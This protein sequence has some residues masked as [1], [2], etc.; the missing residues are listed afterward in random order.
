MDRIILWSFFIIGIVLL[1]F[2]FRKPLIKE[3]KPI[4]KDTILVFLMKAYFSTF[5]GI[6]VAKEK[7]IE[8]PVRFL[9]KYFETSIIFESFLYPIMCVYLFQTTYH[10][11][12]LGIIVQCALYT[13]ALTIIEVFCEKYTDLIH[14]HTWTWMHSFITIFLLSLFVRILMQWINKMDQ[15]KV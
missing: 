8:Y 7:M 13:A 5:I 11:R 1:F 6:F 4:I 9:S 12:F 10:S 3:R 2:S 15:S 14:Y